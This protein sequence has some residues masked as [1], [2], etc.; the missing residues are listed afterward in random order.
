VGC[1]KEQLEKLKEE[2]QA[3]KKNSRLRETATKPEGVFS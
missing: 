3:H 2:K 1:L